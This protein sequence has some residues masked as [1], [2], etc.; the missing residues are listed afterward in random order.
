MGVRRGVGRRARIGRPA[1]R[2]RTGATG[3][4]GRRRFPCQQVDSE[5]PTAVRVDDAVPFRRIAAVLAD[6]I[7]AEPDVARARDAVAS[8]A[9]DA[10]VL[11]ERCL[12]HELGWWA[13]QEIDALLE[14][15]GPTG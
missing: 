4:V 15:A 12:T 3:R 2:Q 9:S 11:I 1:E 6:A 14:D 13:T 5:D 10:D 7:D 8:A